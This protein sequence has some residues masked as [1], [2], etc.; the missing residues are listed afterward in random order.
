ME[1]PSGS[2]IRLILLYL[3]EP[4]KSESDSVPEDND[5]LILGKYS[6]SFVQPIAFIEDALLE[7]RRTQN[8][9]FSVLL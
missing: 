4:P 3:F 7:K 9:A 2:L 1:G 5:L 6:L 8:T